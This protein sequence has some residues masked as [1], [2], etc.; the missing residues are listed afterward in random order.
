MAQA[1]FYNLRAVSCIVGDFIISEYG[2]DGAIEL[3]PVTD[4]VVDSQGLDGI[5]TYSATNDGRRELTIT[6][7]ANG[8]AARD[9]GAVEIAQ[10]VAQ[11]GGLLGAVPVQI[12]DP[13]S[14][15]LVTGDAILKTRPTITKAQ[16]PGSR[17][18]VFSMPRPK[19]V[20]APLATNSIT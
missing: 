16:G 6:V 13:I 15:D 18:W 5:T 1:R 4:A 7:A 17:V 19:V 11:A 14:G 20:S 9:L 2:E 3:S 10:G 8:R 12:L